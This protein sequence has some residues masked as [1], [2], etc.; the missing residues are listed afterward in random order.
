[1][2]KTLFLTA[3]LGLGSLSALG[4][5]FT[6]QTIITIADGT[7]ARGDTTLTEGVNYATAC[8]TR[9]TTVQEALEQAQMATVAGSDSRHAVVKDGI[10]E[11]IITGTENTVSL[12]SAFMV[13]EGTVTI[14]DGATVSNSLG[15]DGC[16][17]SVSG[18]KA[19]LVLDGGHY[20]A[21][22]AAHT[23]SSVAIGTLDGDGELTLTNGSTFYTKQTLFSGLGGALPMDEPAD[24]KWSMTSHYGG[25][26]AYVDGTEDNNYYCY[27]SDKK[28][29]STSTGSNTLTGAAVINV[30]D[31]SQL[32]TGYGFY[33]GNTTLTLS[34]KDSSGKGSTITTG[35]MPE[36]YN[37][38]TKIGSLYGIT[39]IV[40]ITDGGVWNVTNGQYTLISRDAG[41]R[42]KVT[43]DGAGSALNA[44][45]WVMIGDYGNVDVD[46]SSFSEILVT[47]GGQMTIGSGLYVHGA[48]ISHSL[49]VEG[50][51]SLLHTAGVTAESGIDIKVKQ[52]ASMIVDNTL[53]VGNQMAAS[54]ELESGAKASAKR[55]NLGTY[56]TMNIDA[57]SALDLTGTTYHIVAGSLENNGTINNDD[58]V[59]AVFGTLKG[60]G[61]FGATQVVSGGSLIVGNSPGK[62]TYTSFLLVQ[63]TVDFSVDELLHP[64]PATDVTAGWDSGCYSV[65]DMN[66]NEMALVGTISI[67]L[68]TKA[69]AQAAGVESFELVFVTN[70][71]NAS[72][73]T[74]DVLTALDART[75]V[76]DMEGTSLTNLGA[77]HFEMHGNDLVWCYTVTPEPTTATLSLLALAGLAARRRR[78]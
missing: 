40:D 43:I 31:G 14:S 56:G 25:T 65:I 75:S 52:G 21:K 78:K 67:T 34:G 60:S 55:L 5:A 68:S 71:G 26:Y 41:Q 58:A 29:F 33:V 9:V 28:G 17:L 45:G 74:S 32:E 19:K 57:D 72:D 47:N 3:A 24:P 42:S 64:Q 51:G 22:D 30:L 39:A 10:G 4:D 27:V 49:T 50:E 20:T 11:L 2:K 54:L 16:N 73:Y 76:T 23:V 8:P 61:T 77:A 46:H 66:D 44:S 6:P 70:I 36:G 53:Q 37:D 38:N 18:Y 59:L 1:M 69:A 12:K 35:T 7:T 62:Q 48:Q 15:T 63:G 13:R